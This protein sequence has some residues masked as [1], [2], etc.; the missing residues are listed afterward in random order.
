MLDQRPVGTG[1]MRAFA[2]DLAERAAA[3]L[4][5]EQAQQVAA[6]VLEVHAARQL[7]LDQAL[8]ARPSIAQSR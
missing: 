2:E 1:L 7:R 3:G 5:G 6:D 4:A 8:L